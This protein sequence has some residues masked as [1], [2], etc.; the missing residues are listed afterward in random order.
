MTGSANNSLCLSVRPFYRYSY[1]A[2]FG[3]PCNSAAPYC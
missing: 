2:R 1:L 3:D